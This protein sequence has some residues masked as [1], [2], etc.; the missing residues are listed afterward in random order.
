MKYAL[1]AAFGLVLLGATA[2]ADSKAEADIINGQGE[3]IGT[4]TFMEEGKGVKIAISVSKLSPG[5][6]GLHIHAVGK[7]E[8]PNFTS[9]G[10]HLNPEG[11]KHGLES[12]EGPHA[13]DLPNLSVGPDGNAKTEITTD[14]VTL[15]EGKN[16]L[17]QPDGT[18]LVIHVAEDDQKADPIGNA[19]P[20]AACGV[21]KKK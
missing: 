13:G 10:G 11:K 8:G 3:K 19:G 20:R 18:A 15:G 21:I 9:A 17:F 4:A 2:F 12:P 7:C 1:L 5:Q 16:S 6:H 14:R